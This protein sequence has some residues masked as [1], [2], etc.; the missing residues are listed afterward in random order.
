MWFVK[1]YVAYVGNKDGDF[2]LV[3]LRVPLNILFRKKALLKPIE[4]IE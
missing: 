3:K 2:F 1:F 4:T